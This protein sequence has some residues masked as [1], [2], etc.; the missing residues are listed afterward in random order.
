M[1]RSGRAVHLL[2]ADAVHA[3]LHAGG[4]CGGRGG[5]LNRARSGFLCGQGAVVQIFGPPATDRASVV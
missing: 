1:P 3:H 4:R 2:N 5:V